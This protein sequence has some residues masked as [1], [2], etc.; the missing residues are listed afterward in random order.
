MSCSL[1]VP[2]GLKATSFATLE[3]KNRTSPE[4]STGGLTRGQ[5]AKQDALD[6]AELIY[7]IFK[8]NESSG[9]IQSVSGKD[10]NNA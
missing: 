2:V 6:L 8:A 3:A 9:S 1:E 10:T 4:L 7:D 5:Q